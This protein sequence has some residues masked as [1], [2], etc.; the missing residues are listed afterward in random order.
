MGAFGHATGVVGRHRHAA[1]L[2]GTTAVVATYSG[3]AGRVYV[4][5]P[6]NLEAAVGLLRAARPGEW[7]A[8]LFAT[9]LQ[10]AQEYARSIA[11]G[12]MAWQA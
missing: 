9:G 10:A 6:A 5:R 2:T 4:M 1:T 3:P 8:V 12:A 11:N 7:H